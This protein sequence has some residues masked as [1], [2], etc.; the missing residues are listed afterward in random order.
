MDKY[1]TTDVS[2]TDNSFNFFC[3]YVTHNQC[4][5]PKLNIRYKLGLLNI[6]GNKISQLYK[7]TTSPTDFTV[8]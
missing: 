6:F 3:P 2:I 8:L 1:I 5:N 4:T 7:T